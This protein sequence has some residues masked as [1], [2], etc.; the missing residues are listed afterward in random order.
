MFIKLIVN[1]KLS[2]KNLQIHKLRSLLSILGISFGVLSLIIVG[3]VTKM[4]EKKVQL[5]AENFGKNLLIIRAAIIQASGRSSVFSLAHTLKLRDGALIKDILPYVITVAPAFDQSFPARY[6]ENTTKANVVGVTEDYPFLRKIALQKG[7]F[8]SKTH[9]DNYE[10]KA[11][12]GF[13]VW[14]NLFGNENPIGKYILLYRAPFEVVGV[15]APLGVDLSGNDQDNQILIPFTTMTRRLLNVDYLS[16][17]YVQVS[18]E[19]FLS[20]GKKDVT[21]IL[22]KNHNLK[23][24]VKNDFTV[25]SIS[26]LASIKEDSMKLVRELGNTASFLSFLI[27]AL[28]ILAIMILTV[29]ERKKEIGIRRACGAKRFDIMTQFLFE[30]ILLTFFGSLF[31]IFIATI[32]TILV[33]VI[34]KLPIAFSFIQILLSIALSLTLGL[35]SGVYPAKKASEVDPISALQE[36]T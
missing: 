28:G 18:D 7:I 1:A 36:N 32:I 23:E 6:L 10:K 24:G 31:G 4:M 5:E 21:E 8:F 13:K 20:L 3:N 9:F 25:Q 11:I 12:I 2:L 27:G 26:D 30:A 34:G 15:L 17:I 33:S 35:F 19:A 29:S 14:Q 22:R 16:T